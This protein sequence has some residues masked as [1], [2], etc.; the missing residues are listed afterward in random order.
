MVGL[1]FNHC[2]VTNDICNLSSGRHSRDRKV[3]GFTTTFS[4]S[5]YHH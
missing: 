1:G 3:V 2:P 4:I 5:A